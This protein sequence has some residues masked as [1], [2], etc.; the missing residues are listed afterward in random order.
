MKGL[1][2]C[3]LIDGLKPVHVKVICIGRPGINLKIDGQRPSATHQTR[4]TEDGEGE[5]NSIIAL[6]TSN[7]SPRTGPNVIGISLSTSSPV[8]VD[9]ASRS[10]ASTAAAATRAGPSP[11]NM[12]DLSAA[13]AKDVVPYGTRHP[14]SCTLG[15]SPPNTTTTAAS[16]SAWRPPSAA[17]SI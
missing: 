5:G 15:S 17:Q 12:S 8:V 10:M 7:P 3:L 1:A 11:L 13:L 2:R 6:L 16:S 14:R 9:H 4:R